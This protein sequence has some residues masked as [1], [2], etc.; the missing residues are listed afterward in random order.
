GPV[1]AI[2][3]RNGPQAAVVLATVPRLAGDLS[4]HGLCKRLHVSGHSLVRLRAAGAAGTRLAG[5]EVSKD[6]AVDGS[7]V[8]A[9]HRAL[10]PVRAGSGMALPWRPAGDVLQPVPAGAV[11][12]YGC[13]DH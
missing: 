10:A 12:W 8:G 2:A 3:R 5:G 7:G 9:G 11:R 13:A 1:P 4:P 6:L